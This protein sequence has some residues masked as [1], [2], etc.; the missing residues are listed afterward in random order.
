MA[1]LKP[2]ILSTMVVLSL[3]ACQATAWREFNTGDPVQATDRADR[4]R[5][6]VKMASLEKRFEIVRNGTYAAAEE[7]YRND[8]KDPFAALSYAQILR[9]INMPEQAEII[10][11]PLA[12]D[13]VLAGEDIMLEYARVK[14][15]LGD[16]NAA[17]VLAQEASF[18]N[19]SADAL[20]LL[21][22]ALDAQGHHE[23]A[24]SNLRDALDMAG[25]NINLKNKILNNLAV[26]LMAQGR[27][28]EA[29]LIL[30]QII[31]VA[32]A[33]TSVVA[34]NRELAEKL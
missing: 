4:I 34:A 32:G 31:D 5:E 25:M 17:Q 27:K 20:M 18:M 29:E 1:F 24:E 14:L 26:S 7:A 10:L 19:D 13:P 33:G 28:N 6:A 16:F 23:A 8:P 12:E 15:T 22:V 30:S 3:T 2:V 9:Q 21:G 11:K